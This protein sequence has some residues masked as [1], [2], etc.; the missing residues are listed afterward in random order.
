MLEGSVAEAVGRVGDTDADT[1]SHI[2]IGD[3]KRLRERGADPQREVVSL[4]SG[5]PERQHGEL[6][7]PEA[8]DEFVGTNAIADAAGDRAQEFVAGLVAE[9]VVY[10]LEAIEIAV[11]QGATRCLL[12]RFEEGFPVREAS[13]GVAMRGV[14]ELA[15]LSYPA[16]DEFQVDDLRPTPGPFVVDG[17]RVAVEIDLLMGGRRTA[18]GDFFTIEGDKILRLVIFFGPQLS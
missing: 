17:N 14:V 6:V 9:S 15:G 11:E 7:A 10:R 3:L 1:D 2:R 16:H 13:E 4:F 5:S 18:V 8:G 12:Q